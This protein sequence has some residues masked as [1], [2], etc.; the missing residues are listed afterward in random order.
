M[1]KDFFIDTHAHLGDPAFDSDREEVIQRALDAGVKSIIN[2][3]CWDKE[4]GFEGAFDIA[5]KYPFISLSLGVHLHEAD[6]VKD[7]KP[8][9]FMRNAARDKKIV[10][11]GETGLDYHYTHSTKKAQRDIFIEHIKAARE[12]SL[13]LIIHSREADE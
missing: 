1:G 10:A 4:K 5:A 3:L 12:A 9:D 2:I 11:I 13:P 7:S 8:I 6:F